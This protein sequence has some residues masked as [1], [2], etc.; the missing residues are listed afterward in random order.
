MPEIP[1]P[2]GVKLADVKIPPLKARST[3][4]PGQLAVIL[5]VITGCFALVNITVVPASDRQIEP[6]LR[7]LW[8]AFSFGMIGAQAGLLAIAAVLGPGKGLLRHLIAVPL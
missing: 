8:Q 7:E 1:Y 6:R 5:A 4:S 3:L 2:Y